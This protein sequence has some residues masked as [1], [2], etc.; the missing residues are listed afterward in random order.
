[1]TE[2]VS[3]LDDADDARLLNMVR[4]GDA[5]AFAVLQARHQ[6]AAQRLARHL[7]SSPYEVDDVVAE[8]FAWVLAVT[9]RGGGPSNAARP[10]VLTALRRVCY[11][12]LTGQ[13]TWD[14][15]DDRQLPEPGEPFI[16]PSMAGLETAL[17]ARA[18]LSLPERWRAVLW[19]SQVEQARPAY[20]APLLG[21]TRNGVAALSH[22][23]AD[24]L[25]Q[26]YLQQHLTATTGECRLVAERLGAYVR[27]AQSLGDAARVPAHL[28]GCDECRTVYAELADIGGTLR[29]VI[30]PLILGHAAAAYLFGPGESGVAAPPGAG[31]HVGPT[32][33]AG[34]QTATT[35]VLRTLQRPWR[36]LR[37]VHGVAALGVLTVMAVLALVAL[38]TGGRGGAPASARGPA[39]ASIT[40]TGPAAAAHP[41]VPPGAQPSPSPSVSPS[42][43]VIPAVAAA[44]ASA[45]LSAN[46][47][48]YRMMPGQ[49]D[50]LEF[51]V[52]NTGTAATGTVTVSISL[53]AGSSVI[54]AQPS[55][56]GGGSTGQGGGHHGGWDSQNPAAF[57][58][59][60]CQP[61][62]SGATCTHTAI[63]AGQRAYGG[64]AVSISSSGTC[65]QPVR[66]TATTGTSVAT[67]T[68]KLRC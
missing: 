38:M 62:A 45:S 18:Y 30:A 4:A 13:P 17:I 1:M 39:R 2:S 53:P 31:P 51:T 63:G 68:Q 64:L 11:F 36:Q 57:G 49:V 29:A 59:W 47:D 12:R 48:V 34:G 46:L 3:A 7:V 67:A 22:R 42:P 19:H 26:A 65:G 15:A 5:G 33:V 52:A 21:L 23:A 32:A 9:R 41:A 24:G 66:L 56:T 16:E 20:I 25:R 28:N 61:T 55:G 44:P 14:R 35:A 50:Q 54:S 6:P 58:G 40:A 27:D 60:E 37:P 8:A 43:V 10:Y